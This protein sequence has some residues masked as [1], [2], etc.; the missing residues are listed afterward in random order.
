VCATRQ[1]DGEQRAQSDRNAPHELHA[2]FLLPRSAPPPGGGHRGLSGVTRQG[3][4][5]RNRVTPID[6]PGFPSANCFPERLRRDKMSLVRRKGSERRLLVFETAVILPTLVGG[7]LLVRA[8]I[9]YFTWEK[10]GVLV[11]WAAAVSVVELIPVPAWR[12]IH[13]SLGFPLL[14]AL[15]IVQPPVAAGV[16][17]FVGSTDPREFRREVTLLRAIFNRSQVALSVLAASAVFHAFAFIGKE[18]S[19]GSPAIPGSPAWL[20][21]LAA[22]VAAIADYLVNSTMVTLFTSLRVGLPPLQVLKELRIG[23]VSEFLISYLG[24]GLLGLTMAK[25]AVSSVGVWALPAFMAPL[26]LARQMFF[27]SQAL[28]EA[29]KELQTREQV[30][31]SL[32]NAMAEERADERLQIAGYLHDD[33]AQVLFRLSI[34]VDVARK[35]LEKGQ[36]EDVATQLDKIRHSKQET[37]DR[38]R[39]LIRDLHRSPLGAKGLAEALESFTEEVGR[40][41]SIRFHRDVENIDLPA[42]IALLV[43]H[44]AREGVMNALKHAQPRDVWITVREEDDDIVLSLKDN[45]VG[46]DTDAPGPEGHFGMAMMRE[47]AQV[48]GGRFEVESTPGEGTT[49]TVRFPRSLLQQDSPPEPIGG[50][51]AGPGP[52]PLD[53]P[54]GGRGRPGPPPPAP[55]DGRRVGPQEDAS[56]DTPGRSEPAAGDSR[57]TVRA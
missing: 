44:I 49:I 23:S 12:G 31:R 2:V 8:T 45:G 48:G 27:R 36:T 57:P 6:V 9:D 26:L 41:S 47:R 3:D 56:P 7:V 29:H 55:P 24:L 50:G 18:A 34:Q 46:F 35:L 22:M 28:E 17:A 32:S 4:K 42:P 25:F 11:L 52:T 19:P 38:I 1:C 10:V 40:D 14:I 54:E 20:L 39:A 30:L 33:L 13:L 21:V 53:P 51:A 37:S 5:P 15:A 43:Y 16:T